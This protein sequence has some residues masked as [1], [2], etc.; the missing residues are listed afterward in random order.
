MGLVL[1]HVFASNAEEITSAIA[2]AASWNADAMIVV[3]SPLFTANG[4]RLAELAILHRLPTVGGNSFL[5]RDEL[6][7]SYS[8]DVN[9]ALRQAADTVDRILK[10][11]KAA[12]LPVQVIT[13]FSLIINAKTAKALGVTIPPTMLVLADEV[14]E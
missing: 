1:H 9:V 4:A 12:D 13:R 2:E 5:T 6:L 14:I 10:G 3:D 8:G 7:L 11:A